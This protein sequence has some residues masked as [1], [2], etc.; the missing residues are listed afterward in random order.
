M[1]KKLIVLGTAICFLV[2][3]SSTT[4][5]KS[6]PSGAKLY[7]D[8]QYKCETPCTHSD[9]AASGTSKTVLLKKG[10]YRDFTGTIKKEKTEVGPI[11]G[12]IFLLFPLIWMLGYPEEYNF[13]MEVQKETSTLPSVA[14]DKGSPPVMDLSTAS[15]ALE[16]NAKVQGAQVFV[17]GQNK[18]EVP[19][20]V[21]NLSPG[22]YEVQVVKEGYGEWKQR[23]QVE[24]NQKKVIEANLKRPRL[25]EDY[26]VDKV[27]YFENCAF[28]WDKFNYLIRFQEQGRLEGAERSGSFAGISKD[29]LDLGSLNGRWF[30][31]KDKIIIEFKGLEGFPPRR[32]MKVEVDI[33]RGQNDVFP[34]KCESSTEYKHNRLQGSTPMSWDGKTD[35]VNCQMRE[36]R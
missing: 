14:V 2:G 26:L 36:V 8:G 18:G 5:I 6:N 15:G 19:L 20:T 17:D 34:T 27:F 23:I 21:S 1:E 29:S 10:G 32:V 9:S 31:D 7:L 28:G 16:I 11:I 24:P 12:G 4:M 33:R 3:C 22:L 25:D 13:E 30:S 35:I